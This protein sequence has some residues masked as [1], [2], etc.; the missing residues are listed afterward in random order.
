VSVPTNPYEVAAFT[1][2]SYC[3]A[4]DP[5]FVGRGL[6]GL[7]R[8]AQYIHSYLT[9]LKA[10]T[11]I[12]EEEYTDGDFLDDVA[13]YYV[14]SFKDI[15]R[16]C[17]RLHFFRQKFTS[18]AFERALL[19][20][21]AETGE[22]ERDTGAPATKKAPTVLSSEDLQNSYLG[23][24]V[25]RPL[26]KAII[27]RTVLATYDNDSGRR[28]YCATKEYEAHLFGIRLSVR[29]LA[30][31]QQDT[32]LAACAT[33]SLWSAFQKTAELFGTITPTPATITRAANHSFYDTRPLPSRGLRT[34]QMARAIRDVGLEPELVECGPYVPLLS[35]LYGYLQLGLPVVLGIDIEGLGG[36]AVTVTGYSLRPTPQL[37]AEELATVA[38]PRIGVRVDE[39]YV[40]DDGIGPFARIKARYRVPTKADE[41]AIYFEGDWLH[42]DGV[43]PRKLDPRMVIAPVYHKIRLRSSDLQ[44]WLVQLHTLADVI[45]APPG[46]TPALEWRMELTTV[47]KLKEQ[48][49]AASLPQATRRELLLTRLPRFLWQARLETAGAPLFDFLFDATGIAR[50]LPAVTA[51]FYDESFRAQMKAVLALSGI[52]AVLSEELAEFL[53]GCC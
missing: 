4:L 36:H 28:H 33:V 25:V 41:S 51:V 31:Q 43:T 1:E 24:V 6:A 19:G 15:P 35:V 26:P 45:H 11:I 29:S 42:E 9:H 8:Q 3:A 22:G 49:R 32:V 14:K 46:S 23:F 52:T 13:N 16:R 34:E 44:Q 2:E 37:T 10:E 21:D 5:R 50:S 18:E 30:Y 39:F 53:R 7:P 20:G 38:V 40:H 17:R 47:N 48:W 27:G 12:V